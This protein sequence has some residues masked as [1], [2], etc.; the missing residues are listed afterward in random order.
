M[1]CFFYHFLIRFLLR[2][3]HMSIIE[4]LLSLFVLSYPFFSFCRKPKRAVKNG[5]EGEAKVKSLLTKFCRKHHNSHILNNI[6][7]RLHD[8]STT[9]IDHI[10]IRQEGI[11]V[12]E[13][14]HYNGWIFACANAKFWMQTFYKKKYKFQNPILQNYRHVKAIQTI[15]KFV[16]PQF[17]HNIVVFSG[18]A[19]FKTNKPHNVFYLE[20]LI[21]ALETYS[22]P[23]LSDEKVNFLVEHLESIRLKQSKKTDRLHQAYLAKK[24]S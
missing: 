3:A 21:S 5:V 1:T 6:T 2:C 24:F 11:F 16:K 8:G 19:K 18:N 10:L 20:E 14:K 9:Q 22:K 13:T 15:F 17:I 23:I 4:I 7:L 12:I